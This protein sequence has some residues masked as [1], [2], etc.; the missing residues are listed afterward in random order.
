M[1]LNSYSS[2]KHI[3]FSRLA[4]TLLVRYK[5]ESTLTIFLYVPKKKKIFIFRRWMINS[6]PF[7]F[8]F[9]YLQKVVFSLNYRTG[10]E[11]HK[12]N[13]CPTHVGVCRALDI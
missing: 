13:L 4:C 8:R 12:S 6:I 11:K 9:Y 3:N 5:K 10:F 1:F 7:L 2:G